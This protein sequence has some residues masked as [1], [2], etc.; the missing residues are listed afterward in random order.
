MI[1]ETFGLKLQVQSG[2]A[3]SLR[4]LSYDIAG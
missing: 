4:T 1:F 3:V 2:I